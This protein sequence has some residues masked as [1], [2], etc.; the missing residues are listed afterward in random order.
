MVVDANV[1]FNKANPLVERH[2]NY[3]VTLAEDGS[4]QAH[5]NLVYQHHARKRLERCQQEI[6]YDRVYEQNMERCY[7]NYLRLIVPASAKL[8]SGPRVIVA[9]QS[10]LRGQ[11]TTGEIDVASPGSDK[12]SWG[13]LFLIA[14]EKNISLDYV[15]TLPP[16]TAHAVEDHWEYN[17]YLQKQPGTLAPTV[18][19]VVTLPEG[20][21]LLKS[22]PKPL[23]QQER[24][25]TYL[26]SLKTDQQIE[27]FY[28]LP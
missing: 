22:Q 24:V 13:Q 28:Y 27:L 9:G 21:L 16:G 26:V 2:L 1:G 15:Y 4:A 19:V 10:L 14:P 18:E 7:W 8:I 5:A 11:P 12:T 6:R 23:S 3:Q 17:L 20:A 25:I